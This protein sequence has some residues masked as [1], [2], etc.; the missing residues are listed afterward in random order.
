M[1]RPGAAAAAAWCYVA[2]QKP[3][4]TTKTA[5]NLLLR[6]IL[7]LS[8]FAQHTRRAYTNK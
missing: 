4:G 8:S 3:R 1:T 7:L 5:L 2:F 6:S